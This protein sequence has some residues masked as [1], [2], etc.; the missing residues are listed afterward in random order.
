MRRAIPNDIPTLVALMSQFYGEAGYELDQALAGRAL[1]A[2]L[3]DERLGYVWLIDAE[4]SSVGYVVLSL[5]FGMEYGGLMACIDDLFVA[6]HSRNK[7]LSTAALI[8]VRDFCKQIGIR[9]ITVEVGH[10]NRPAQTVYRR[11]GLVEA[12]DRQLL[13]LALESPTHVV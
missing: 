2:M 4:G 1:G 9:A 5:R 6:P 13:V 11:L 10:G 8:E 12:P 3:A 7:G